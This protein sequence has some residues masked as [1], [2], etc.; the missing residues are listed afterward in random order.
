MF[1]YCKK[2]IDT[3][4][5]HFKFFK[6]ECMDKRIREVM[7]RKKMCFTC[8]GIERCRMHPEFWLDGED[9]RIAENNKLFKEFPDQEELPQVPE[10]ITEDLGA[11]EIM[12]E[13]LETEARLGI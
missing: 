3:Y 13:I 2:Y 9:D 7:M 10:D 8:P 11:I 1:K 12:K 6:P 4:Y 5:V